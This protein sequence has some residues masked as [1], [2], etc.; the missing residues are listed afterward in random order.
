MKMQIQLANASSICVFAKLLLPAWE[1]GYQSKTKENGVHGLHSES[2]NS[3]ELPGFC[4]EPSL[5]DGG[6]M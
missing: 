1:I 5:N 6:M 2:M 3:T 4:V